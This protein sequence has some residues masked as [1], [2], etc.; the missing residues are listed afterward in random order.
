MGAPRKVAGVQSTIG[1]SGGQRVVTNAVVPGPR[2]VRP[3]PSPELV[4]DQ[5]QLS[6]LLLGMHAELDSVGAAVA[7]P[8]AGGILVPGL[9]FTGG[10]PRYVSHQLQRPLQGWLCVR[11]QNNAW[12]GFQ[13]AND[14]GRNLNV[15]V[16][17]QTGSTGIFDLYFF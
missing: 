17:L 13:L 15:E 4:N 7:T 3:W 5:V 10:T 1:T 9:A 8:F 6:R 2:A 16:K 14:K 12:V 11:S